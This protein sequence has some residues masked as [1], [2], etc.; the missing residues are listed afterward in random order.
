[1]HTERKNKL[2][3][4]LLKHFGFEPTQDQQKAITVLI[5][6]LFDPLPNPIFILKGYAGTGKTSLISA[7][8]KTANDY[9]VTTVL[10]APTGRAAKVL[11]NYSKKNA[12]TIHKRIYQSITDTWGNTTFVLQKNTFRKAIFIV[13]EA[14]MISDSIND[15][16][17]SL[18]QDL[19]HYVYSGYN[20]RL[21][22]LGDTAQLPPVG[23]NQSPALDPNYLN[24]LFPLSIHT[25]QLK[26]VMRQE[27]DSGILYNATWLRVQLLQNPTKHPQ[28]LLNGFTDI[29]NIN[30]KE[31]Q[32][33]LENSYSKHG[34]DETIIIT[35]SN[36]TANRYNQEIRYRIKWQDNEIA[37]GD[38]GMVVKNNYYWLDKNPEVGFIANGDFFE[39]TKV[40]K[41]IEI[42]GYRFAEVIIKL[43]DYP[44]LPAFE[45][46]VWL[47]CLTTESA[48]MPN[49][50]YQKLQQA[51][52]Q[53]YKEEYKGKALKEALKKNPYLNALQVKF[54][55]CV[56]CHKAQGGQ[57]EE[58]YIDYGF[59]TPNLINDEFYR[60]LYTAI[61]RAKKKVYLINFNH[62]FFYENKDEV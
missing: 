13:D 62:R 7:F 43:I 57:W 27:T 32:E 2:K 14:S 61:T 53:D 56:T 1:L 59:L 25:V 12:T 8:I 24:S 60:W 18:L 45:T 54:G 22:F 26:Q 52:L 46:I 41:I 11:S 21:L 4:L 15:W 34:Y 29:V 50:D 3:Q 31:L 44:N 10:M 30:G 37:V 48:S 40:I 28:F 36:K 47:N 49:T 51:V 6:F 16:G 17:S 23:Y 58:V 5:D 42:Y 39:I 35:R 33:Y 55:Y 38:L 9:R 19:L 20:C